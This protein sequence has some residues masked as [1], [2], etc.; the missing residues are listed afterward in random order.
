LISQTATVR[1]ASQAAVDRAAL[2]GLGEGH[3]DLG[4]P[5]A[6]DED[7]RCLLDYGCVILVEQSIRSRAHVPGPQIEPTVDASKRGADPIDSNAPDLPG[8][9]QRGTRPAVSSASLI[10][11]L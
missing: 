3:L 10:C 2:T 8:L 6:P 11:D 7:R 9:D 4:R 5:D 1:G